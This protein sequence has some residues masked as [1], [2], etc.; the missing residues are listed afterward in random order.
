MRQA[1]VGSRVISGRA[2]GVPQGKRRRIGPRVGQTWGAWLVCCL[3]P[4]SLAANP[5]LNPKRVVSSHTVDLTPLFKWWSAHQGIRPLSSWVHLSGPVVGTNAGAWVI[6]ATVE[7]AKPDEQGK[8]GISRETTKIL[9]ENPPLDDRMEFETL[10]NR[11]SA[12]N[13]RK[14]E[15]ARQ[16]NQAKTLDAQTVAQEHA[17]RANRVRARVLALEDKQ[18]KQGENQARAEQKAIDQQIKDVKS[19]LAAFPKSEAYLVDCF[20]LDLQSEY[21]HMPVYD[22]GRVLR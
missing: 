9:L 2:P 12:L 18:L 13:A 8:G 15:L 11:L 17:A 5:A 6:E 16:E 10:S 7:G 1:G 19:R 22:Y 20:A 4:L 3:L 14:I 21:N